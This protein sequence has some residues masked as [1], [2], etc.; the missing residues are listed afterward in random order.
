LQSFADRGHHVTLYAYESLNVPQG[1]TLA[2]A[3]EIVTKAE[4]DAVFE[5]ASG[6]IAQFSDLFRYE[7]LARHGG[8]WVDTDVVCLSSVLPET[9][10][11]LAWSNYRVYTGIMHFPPRHSLISEAASQARAKIEL[12]ASLPRTAIGP[13]LMMELM[14]RHRVSV[15]RKEICYK[16]GSNRFAEFGE[17][18]RETS[19]RNELQDCP[20][21]HWWAERF[22]GGNFPAEKLPPQGSYLAEIFAMHGGDKAQH[23]DLEDWREHVQCARKSLKARRA[24]QSKPRIGRFASLARRL[25]KV[26]GT[27]SHC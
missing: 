6:A 9:D 11:W 22:R 17:P 16:V 21:L 13:D 7:M 1:V 24:A 5:M 25:R 15:H 19:L 3:E 18:D 26:I 14:S 20:M 12:L 2:N 4:R 8:W 27:S 10:T 23:V